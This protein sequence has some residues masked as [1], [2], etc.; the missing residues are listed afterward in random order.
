MDNEEIICVHSLVRPTSGGGAE[1]A[2]LMCRA[3]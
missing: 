2:A 3:Q 1:K